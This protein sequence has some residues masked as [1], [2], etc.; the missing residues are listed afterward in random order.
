MKH[1]I[2]GYDPGDNVSEHTPYFTIQY[3]PGNEVEIT[4]AAK[5]GGSEV[6]GGTRHQMLAFAD[7]LDGIRQFVIDAYIASARA[8]AVCPPGILGIGIG[9]TANMAADLAKEAACLRKIG[10]RHPEPIFAKLE[11][12]LEQAINS[13]GI[14]HMG[15]GGRTS[16]LAVHVEYSY[17]HIA[18]VAVATSTN[19]CVARRGTVRLTEDSLEILPNANWFGG[20]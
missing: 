12:E 7:G 1:P 15:A 13:L 8:G 9:G 16:V 6:F 5:G 10:S 20:R 4:Y 2:T 11:E 19:C 3:V 14:G 18:G 17:T